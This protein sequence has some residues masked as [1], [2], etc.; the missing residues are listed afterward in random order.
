MVLRVTLPAITEKAP[1]GRGDP[2]T[3]SGHVVIFFP[4]RH[5][6]EVVIP[7]EQETQHLW[8]GVTRQE[9]KR[10]HCPRPGLGLRADSREVSPSP[11]R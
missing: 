5:I 4:P 1:S 2:V 7:L 3:A 8:A 10:S 11:A 6:D 9:G